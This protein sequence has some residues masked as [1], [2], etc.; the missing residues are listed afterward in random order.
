MIDPMNSVDSS[1]K[2]KKLEEVRNDVD[3][4]QIICLEVQVEMSLSSCER[5]EKN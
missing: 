2:K 1:K 5:Q 3:T 4:N